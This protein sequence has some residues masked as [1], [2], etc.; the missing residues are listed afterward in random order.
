MSG[1]QESIVRHTPSLASPAASSHVRP[2]TSRAVTALAH[3][4]APSRRREP[5]VD[6]RRERDQRAGRGRH[7]AE[8]DRGVGVD[9]GRRFRQ[10]PERAWSESG[11][12]NVGTHADVSSAAAIVNWLTF[13]ATTSSVSRRRRVDA[14]TTSAGD[15]SRSTKSC[16][17][18]ADTT[19][20]RAVICSPA[21]DRTVQPAPRR[22]T[23]S[24]RNPHRTTPPP[25]VTA[26]VS[27]ATNARDP[28]SGRP[29]R[30]P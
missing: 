21:V 18:I 14:G 25:S 8:R 11:S 30:L 16:G 4:V 28:P 26:A 12:P 23:D 22:S 3:I 2:W 19:A 24:T 7:E 1:R 6:R 13:D 17:G 5:G 29:S 9:R 27:A 10:Q 20:R 15:S